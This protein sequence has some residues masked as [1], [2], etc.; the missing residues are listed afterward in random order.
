MNFVSAED[1]L[2]VNKYDIDRDVHIKIHEDICQTCEA[3][4]CLVTESY[5]TRKLLNGFCPDL[6]LEYAMNTDN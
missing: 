2:A 1:K 3:H 5:V 4:Y 6:D